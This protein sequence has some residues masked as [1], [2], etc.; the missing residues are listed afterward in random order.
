ML[1]FVLSLSKDLIGASLN[2]VCRAEHRSFRPE[3]PVRGAEWIPRVDRGAGKPLLA[4]PVESK[5]RRI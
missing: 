2:P 1:P 5:E 3:W 4:T